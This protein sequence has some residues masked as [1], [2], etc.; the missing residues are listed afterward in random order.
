MFYKIKIIDDFLAEVDFNELNNHVLNDVKK[1]EKKVY[2][3]RIYKDG[4][5][6]AS[7]LKSETI[8]RL[9]NNYHSKAIRILGDFAPDKIELYQ[10]SDFHIVIIGA[11][12]SYPIHNDK[13]E[14][15]LS[16]VVY[17]SPDKSMGTTLHSPDKK[18]SKTVEWKKNRAIFFSRTKKTF[19]SYKSDSKSNRITLVYNLMTTDIKSV[20]RAE[21]VF[22]P[23]VYLKLKIDK[24]LMMLKF[25]FLS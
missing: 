16:G 17:L 15:L 11:D 14:K 20:C 12:Y 24:F 19:H 25:K 9:H 7:C 6:E 21:K 13:H 22:Y 4:T 1:K 18:K 10:Y 8:K 2:H 23:Y 5:I 3:N